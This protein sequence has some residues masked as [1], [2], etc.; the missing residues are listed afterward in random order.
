MTLKVTTPHIGATANRKLS[1]SKTNLP[2]A[3]LR[4][5]ETTMHGRR[6]C[7]FTTVTFKLQ[8]SGGELDTLTINIDDHREPGTLNIHGRLEAAEIPGHLRW[9]ADAIA[10]HVDNKNPAFHEHVYSEKWRG[11]GA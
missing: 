6:E 10:Q 8:S 7:D 11:G 1:M 4:Q 2:P 5:R 3:A 9:L